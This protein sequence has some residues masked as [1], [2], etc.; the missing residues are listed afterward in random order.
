MAK[1]KN[2]YA[3]RRCPDCNKIIQTVWFKKSQHKAKD[4]AESKH[5]PQCRKHVITT[6]K[7][8]KKS[9]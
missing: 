8:I 2:I 5:C 6:V 1:G 9:N 4:L 7:E 3:A